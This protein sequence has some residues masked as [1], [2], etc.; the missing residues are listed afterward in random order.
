MAQL[1][2][3][4]ITSLDGYVADTDG[5]WDWAVPDEEVHSFVNELERPVG[6]Y[7]Y[8]RE[9]YD[10]MRY[11]DTAHTVPDQPREALDYA[12]LWQAADKIVYSRTL[13]GVTT[14]RTRL[15]REFDPVAVRALKQA[16]DR[17]VSVGGPRL[18]AEALRAGLVDEIRQIAY[19][20]IVGGGKRFLPDGLRLDLELLDQRRFGNG[21]IYLRYAVKGQ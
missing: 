14:G 20:V 13:A 4:D 5:K 6:T 17:S 11:W 21:A 9:L 12:A 19:P 16:A 7:L 10:V 8:G 3:T 18:A 2:T 1:I 15:E